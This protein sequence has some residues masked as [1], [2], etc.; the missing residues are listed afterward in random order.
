[1]ID[2]LTR[3]NALQVLKKNLNWLKGLIMLDAQ[4]FRSENKPSVTSSAA[5]IHFTRCVDSGN[6]KELNYGMFLDV[7]ICK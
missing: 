4:T 2:W 7:Y 5:F 1:M 3:Y 6:I